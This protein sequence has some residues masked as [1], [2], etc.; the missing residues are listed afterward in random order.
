MQTM[1]LSKDNLMRMQHW[2]KWVLALLV[3]AACVATAPAQDYGSDATQ[4][5]GIY[6]TSAGGETAQVQTGSPA[7]AAIFTGYSN[8]YGAYPV[9]PWPEVSPYDYS[10][11]QTYWDNGLWYRKVNNRQTEYFFGLDYFSATLK[12]PKSGTE[13]GFIGLPFANART[14]Y[15]GLGRIFVGT[16]E[17]IS[18]KILP[19]SRHTTEEFGADETR[20]GFIARFGAVQA[21]DSGFEVT[22]FY[23]AGDQQ[24]VENPAGTIDR[25]F[26]VTASVGEDSADTFFFDAFPDYGRLVFDEGF[27]MTFDSKAWGA[28]ANFITTPLGSNDGMNNF[29]AM[30]GVMYLGINENFGLIGND[31]GLTAPVVGGGRAYIVDAYTMRLNSKL[32]S[33]LVGPQVGLRWRLGGEKLL[34]TTEVKGAFTVNFERRRLDVTNYGIATNFDAFPVFNGDPNAAS[35]RDR[36]VEFSPV[37]EASFMAEL[38][39]M[40]NLPIVSRIPGFKD[41]KFRIGYQFTQAWDIARATEAVQYDAPLPK[42]NQSRSNWHIG[43][44]VAGF[45]WIH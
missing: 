9:Q 11:D 33:H 44:M 37:I 36:G 39:I 29:H 7:D 28:Q 15:S 19:D 23:T 13:G 21:D 31:S 17:D 41:S 20:P 3:N 40:Q 14:A 16:P 8:A 25:F 32:T 24:V 38:P 45:T 18:T 10:F 26:D 27:L 4:D 43:G 30:I 2:S 34:L 12:R 5:A 6:R 42:L 35:L 1:R 22:G